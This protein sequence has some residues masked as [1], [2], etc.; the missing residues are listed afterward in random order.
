MYITY[1]V[2]RTQIYLHEDQARALARRSDARG[3][4]SS[5]LIREAIERYLTEP[6]DEAA[7]LARQRAALRDAFGSLRRLPQGSAYVDEVRTSDRERA[8]RLEARWRSR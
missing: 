6:E 4:T 7:E 8:K 1:I 5:H 2:K 3:V